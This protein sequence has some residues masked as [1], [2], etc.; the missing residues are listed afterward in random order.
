MRHVRF[1]TPLSLNVA[2]LVPG[3][4]FEPALGMLL[5][6]LS[7]PMTEGATQVFYSVGT[8]R[9]TLTDLKVGSPTVTIAAG[10]AT[11]SIAQATNV[12]VGDEISYG[13]GPTLVYISGRSS[14]TQYTVTDR[15]GAPAANVTGATVNRIYRAFA[16]LNIAEANS[17]DA[18]HLGTGNLVGAD[19]QLNWP[20]YNDGILTDSFVIGAGD[21]TTGPSHYIRIYTPAATTEVGVSQRHRGFFGSGF[22][23]RTTNGTTIH[24]DQPYVR[25][26]GLTIEVTVNNN[27]S[28]GGIKSQPLV[29]GDI[30][31]S[32]SIVRGV[33]TA[34]VTGGPVGIGAGNVGAADHRLWNNVVYGFTN[35]AA[36]QSFG[37]ALVSGT[38]Y[39]FNNTVFNC[40][41]GILEGS[42]VAA[43]ELRN[44]VSINDALNV[45]NV[46]FQGITDLVGSTNVSSDAT[47]PGPGSQTGK[48]A[49]AAYFT[50]TIP[51]SEDLHLR[52][53]SLIL[54]GANGTDL[55]AHA[56]LPVTNDVDG[57]ARVQP[58][59]GADEAGGQTRVKSGTYVG[60]GTSQSIV[61]VGFRPDFVLVS[62][63]ST[64]AGVN[65]SSGHTD[66]MRTSTMAGNV[67]K[68]AYVYA[69]HPLVDRITSLDVDGFSV[70]HPPNHLAT[71]D[72][73]GDP[74]RCV[75]HSGVRYYWVAFQAAPGEMAVGTYTG[76]GAATQDVTTVGFQPDYTLVLS[77]DAED[78]IQRFRLMPADYSFDFDGGSQCPAGCSR[79]PESGIRT[80]LANGFRVGEYVNNNAVVYHYV[81]WKENA[82]RIKVGTY[83][84]DGNDDRSFSG[85]GFR[86]EVVHVMNGQTPVPTGGSAYKTASTGSN[87]D[88]SLVYVAYTNAYQ[89][90]DA[91]QAL[92][93]DGF[94]VG[95]GGNVNNPGSPNYY[96]AFGPGSALAAPTYYRS[97]GTAA[98]FVNQGTITLTAGSTT[99]TK[100]GGAGFLASNRGRG[101]RLT[102]GANH[103]QILS[104]DSDD[105]LTL[106]SPAVQSY[107]GGTYTI[108]R[109]FT[110]LAAWE[111]CV[112][113]GPCAYFP[114]TNP[115]LIA[116]NRN[117]M[118][119]AYKDSEFDLTADFQVIGSTTDAQHTI[120]LTADGVNRHHG[121]PGAGVVLDAQLGGF[122]IWIE[123]SYVTVEWLEH[124]RCRTASGSIQ[125]GA[126]AGGT[127]GVVVQHMLVHDFDS[128][129]I[130]LR[131]GGNKN[132]TVR[133]S[134][135]W[136]GGTSGID[137]D[138]ATD[139]LIIENSSV[140]GPGT[141]VNAQASALTIRNTIATTSGT[142]FTASGGS[143]AG[144]NNTSRDGTA[145]G[146]NPQTGV[147]AAS[148]FVIP[149]A[150]LH[151]KSGAN[152]A[153]DTGLTLSPSFLDIDGGSRALVAN[154]DRGADEREITTAVELVAFQAQSLDK[155]VSLFWET[156]SELDNLG[157]HL[158]R[159]TAAAGPYARITSTLIPGLG[160][161]PAGARYTYRDTE[162][163]NGTT[164]FYEI[165][166]VETTGATE[167]HGPVSA[168][169]MAGLSPGTGAQAASTRI[170]YGDPTSIA[171]GVERGR[172]E[173]VLELRTGGFYAEPQEDGSVSIAI[174]DFTALDGAGSPS[175]PVKR[176]W[177]DALAGRKVTLLSV[178]AHDVE[179]FSS[180]R[181]SRAEI[182]EMVATPEGTVRAGGRRPGGAFRGE[183]LIPSSA[184]RIV[185]VG[186]QSEEK[187]ALLELA[188]LRWDGARGEL[189]LARRLVVR[190]SLR[191]REPAERATSNGRGRRDPGPRSHVRN[192]VVARLGTTE[193]GLYGVRYEEV[194]PTRRGVPTSSLRLS[195]QGETVAYHLHPNG[196]RFE[197]GS[198]LYFVSDGAGANPYGSEA[199]YELEVGRSGQRMAELD[200]AP[201]GTS[202]P[203]YTH[204][205]EREENRYY[206]AGLIDAPDVWLWDLILA[207]QSKSYSFDVDNLEPGGEGG[208][209]KLSLWLQGASDF[210]AS[211]DH[212]VRVYVNESAVY[213]LSWDGKEARS[214][215]VELA[216]G[217]LREGENALE[218]ENAGD[219]E[220]AYSMV[221]LDR[222]AVEYGRAAH[223]VDG[224][225]EGW[226]SAPGTAEVS[227]LQPGAHVLDVS[228][229]APAW[230]RNAEL[231][232]DGL[233]RFRAEAGRKYLAVSPGEVHHPVVTKPRPT[234][235]KSER[236]RADYLLV[237]PE[238]FLRAAMPLVELRRRQ[239][240][241]AQAVPI[242]DVYSEF[243][244][245]EKTP[246]AVKDFLSYAYHHWRQPSPRYVVLLGDG[247]Y[248]FKDYLRTGASNQVP[249]RMLKTSFLWTASDPSYAA[250]NGDDLLP[251]LAI[252]RLPAA[253]AEEARVMAEK[254]VAYETGEA[255]LGRSAVVL[256]AD[257]PDGAGDFEADAHRLAEG[258]LASRNPDEIFL[259][260]LGAET[261]R[262]AIVERLDQG[263][264]LMSYL[265]HGGIHLWA[266]ENFFN[267]GD[268]AS[269][270]SQ[271]QQPVLL[272]MN[273]LNGYFQFPYFRSLAEELVVAKDKGA[274]ASFSPSGLSLNSPAQR[275]HEALLRELVEGRHPRLGDAVL[276]AQAAYTASGAFP[277]LLSI[278]HLFGD[279]ALTLR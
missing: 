113:G 95:Q 177:V 208:A 168:T 178:E 173:L 148:V 219:T 217:L 179:A 100:T 79:S 130:R 155:A 12:G 120:R 225:L 101:D 266:N 48:T 233:L 212:H 144:T 103:Y 262:S 97:I 53:T 30:R 163:V 3:T 197:P 88:Y 268:V 160:S 274:I 227:G 248:D 169:P 52:A 138:E 162:L 147:T 121:I 5:L 204:R 251:D 74:Y 70:G 244:F 240:L 67:S 269:L 157:F 232:A 196:S 279:P 78:P 14:A 143:L 261:T 44:N 241:V 149:N 56:F 60:N 165:E 200:R 35:N 65:G 192:P 183:G 15:L 170:R 13:A 114:M 136:G 40:K 207:P 132:L 171:L 2:K 17:I 1:P 41:I 21:Y 16:S 139:T 45:N 46:D 264:S 145:P 229:A 117:E 185:S 34:G 43:G 111:N 63:D 29:A 256:V 224:R 115:S 54:W 273:C 184:A 134:M 236:H 214:F 230:L 205:T 18:S 201:S 152:V 71:N 193:N 188:P 38:V 218:L 110:T 104:V 85:V 202:R 265:G 220:A 98:D 42:G 47:A 125:A 276:A 181:P 250:V 255:G 76:N 222:F 175:I 69:Y 8:S 57:A 161:S 55:S 20:C 96:I 195:R 234:R 249:P 62:A 107:T 123:D 25:I 92:E 80:E 127:T 93:A 49:Y 247:T 51:G 141:G 64:N 228:G 174:P 86:P 27:N 131:G 102:I 24:N 156:G 128:V 119:I 275:F 31:I 11:F 239:G 90:P 106:A 254:I 23:I 89:G 242:E 176:T 215:E 223:G 84:G 58:D 267:T 187:K 37:I 203:V 118:D 68:A 258:V 124:V 158:Y 75:N 81:A 252:G 271:P 189:V 6:L 216:P 190:L 209:S 278:Y 82:G 270:G 221:M 32:H 237:G 108:A 4:R 126:S 61:G 245:G 36:Q 243:G 10:V 142:N 151:L 213:E 238:P 226:W 153:V 140:D 167:L 105:R 231:G 137:G 109:Q 235:L 116:D 253:T 257:N 94:Q 198:V 135:V 28:S 159:S 263:A 180:L 210:P 206:Q 99:V 26:E 66:V 72:N 186:F 50:S 166:D 150:D 33:I 146:A 277:E 172:E 59:I 19:I 211:P 22:Q 91:I 7:V 154:W 73:P 39:A 122:S 129:G 164:Y 83:T 9:A 87:V 260:R 112:D 191:E 259:S 272:T 199:V 133:N 194:M 182:S 246:G 77:D